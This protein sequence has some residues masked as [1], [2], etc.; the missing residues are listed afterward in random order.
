MALRSNG[1]NEAFWELDMTKPQDSYFDTPQNF[2]ALEPDGGRIL[3][4][5][6]NNTGLSLALPM[7]SKPLI[8]ALTDPAGS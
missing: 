6:P 5:G 4:N 7:I 8:W 1:V 3:R 2:L